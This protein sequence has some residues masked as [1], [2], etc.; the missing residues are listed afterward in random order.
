MKK[1]VRNSFLRGRDILQK[2]I[3]KQKRRECRENANTHLA[4]HKGAIFVCNKKSLRQVRIFIKETNNILMLSAA[5]CT[6]FDIPSILLRI[7]GNVRIY[8]NYKHL[9]VSSCV[10]GNKLCVRHITKSNQYSA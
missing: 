10:L 9:F 5:L 1:A 3:L 7:G 4:I 8:F 6:E 2:T